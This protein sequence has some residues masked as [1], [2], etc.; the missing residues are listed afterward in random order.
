M[1]GYVFYK[2]MT[3]VP[4]SSVDFNRRME[5][6]AMSLQP[7]P[8]SP[9]QWALVEELMTIHD[10]IRR[11]LGGKQSPFG[12]TD[13]PDYASIYTEARKELPYPGD[14]PDAIAQVEQGNEEEAAGHEQKR[15][16]AIKALGLMRE[17]GVIEGLGRLSGVKKAV[18][19]RGHGL[20]IS[21]VNT[22]LAISRSI[23]RAN[24]A[25]MHLA[26]KAGDADEFVGAFE[27][28]LSL[29]RI[30]GTQGAMLDRLVANA[31]DALAARRVQLHVMANEVDEAT[32]GRLLDV[33]DRVGA[34]PSVGASMEGERLSFLDV[35]QATH[36]DN[37]KGD[38]ICLPAK[39][40]NVNAELLSASRAP[41]GGA[42]ASLGNALWFVFPSKAE[43]TAKGN[44]Y[45]D[46][47]VAYVDAP[48][49]SRSR[50]KPPHVLIE[51]LPTTYKLLELM[52]PAV[53]STASSTDSS[54]MEINAT[55]I[56]L[57]IR[58]FEL[59]HGKAPGSLGELAPSILTELPPDQLAKD[60][61]F[62]YKR[63][64]EPD[65][66]GRT[67]LLYSVGAD[68]VDQGGKPHP[69]TRSNALKANTTEQIDYVINAPE[70]TRR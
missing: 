52:T 18:R 63:L 36:S 32:C 2:G 51:Q 58:I 27:N 7:D 60:A 17:R 64:E 68:G 59:R 14:G 28:T 34:R 46:A 8:S 37:G 69:K 31:I 29:A 43:M 15:Q 55:R 67:F 56:L 16:I 42:F 1:A 33:I 39:F 49:A 65:E 61:K 3:A 48:G 22:D 5:E 57:A 11:E 35:V 70:D 9:N 45:Y 10:S 30:V 25:R 44:E 13:G 6:H 41:L 53:L 19:P 54:V 24:A 38:G 66:L 47:A 20:L 62:R 4:G 23:A 26:A 40:G 12:D 21:Q 50:L